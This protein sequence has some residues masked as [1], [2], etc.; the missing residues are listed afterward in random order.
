M[1]SNRHGRQRLEVRDYTRAAGSLGKIDRDHSTDILCFN[2]ST[3]THE[4]LDDVQIA[5]LT[6]NVQGCKPV[7]GHAARENIRH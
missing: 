1:C 6:G 4:I 3:F 7:L 2:V 5:L